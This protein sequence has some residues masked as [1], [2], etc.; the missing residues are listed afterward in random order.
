MRRIFGDLLGI[1][2]TIGGTSM[3]SIIDTQSGLGLSLAST[4]VDAVHFAD[5]PVQTGEVSI[6]VGERT[7]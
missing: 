1:D 2:L 6:D 3:P 5:E 7:R 4:V